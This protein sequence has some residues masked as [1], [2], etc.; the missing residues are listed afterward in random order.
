MRVTQAHPFGVAAARQAT[1]AVLITCRAPEGQQLFAL[2][3][4][5]LTPTGMYDHPSHHA[6]AGQVPQM[7]ATRMAWFLNG[8]HSADGSFVVVRGEADCRQMKYQVE[9]GAQPETRATRRARRFENAVKRRPKGADVSDLRGPERPRG[10]GASK[11]KGAD[12]RVSRSRSRSPAGE[13]GD[14]GGKTPAHQPSAHQARPATSVPGAIVAM[15]MRT[16]GGPQAEAAAE[17]YRE[18]AADQDRDLFDGVDLQPDESGPGTSASG[19][20][21]GSDGAELAAA[22]AASLALTPGVGVEPMDE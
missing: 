7:D 6:K 19:A 10:R 4:N 20:V 14:R 3:S 21:G 12:G 2:P 16:I 5:M 15:G 22:A 8:H 11:S 17:R 13:A 1:N 9:H 18:A